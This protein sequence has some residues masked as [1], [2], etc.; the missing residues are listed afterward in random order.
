MPFLIQL[1]TTPFLSQADIFNCHYSS[2]P[3]AIT[4]KPLVMWCLP[5]P[6]PSLWLNPVHYFSSAISR[7]SHAAL[8]TGDTPESS[9]FSTVCRP[10]ERTLHVQFFSYVSVHF[11]ISFRVLLPLLFLK[12]QYFFEDSVLSHLCL[13]HKCSLGEFIH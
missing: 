1:A 13:L 5:S 12:N 4:Q 2:L 11:L 9:T 6:R 8:L 3:P 10:K 7:D